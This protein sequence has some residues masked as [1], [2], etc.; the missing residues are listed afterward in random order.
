MTQ[1]VGN[2]SRIV[3]TDHRVP[4]ALVCSCGCIH[5]SSEIRPYSLEDFI[6]YKSYS[7]SILSQSRRIDVIELLKNS[8]DV[9]ARN[10][11]GSI[12]ASRSCRKWNSHDR[13]TA[14]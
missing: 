5:G 11:H 1:E 9:N 6:E 7:E 8:G 4:L 3:I 2:S 13:A 10:I 12:P 14:D